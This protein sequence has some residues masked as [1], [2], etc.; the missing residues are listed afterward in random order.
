ME[1]REDEDPSLKVGK[2]IERQRLI[3]KE[4]ERQK[5]GDRERESNS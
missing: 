2:E 4:T 3:H 1:A 5:D